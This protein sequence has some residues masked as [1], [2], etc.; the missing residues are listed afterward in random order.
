MGVAICR[1][2][3]EDETDVDGATC[4]ICDE[5]L[6]VRSDVRYEVKIE[7][8]A[9]YDPMEI[10]DEDLNQDHAAKIKELIQKM[11][12]LSADEAQNQVYRKFAFDLCPACQR[13]Y[14]K[15]PL[16]KADGKRRKVDVDPVVRRWLLMRARETYIV[17]SEI[18]GRVRAAEPPDPR[19]A[20]LAL[21]GELMAGGLLQAG[22]P[23]A[24]EGTFDPWP[25]NSG[26]MLTRLEADWDEIGEVVWFKNT[27]AGNAEA[28]RLGSHE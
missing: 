22:V 2:R 5:P 18:A 10:T 11:E 6:L 26:R 3:G 19:R 14:I 23:G 4:D 21:L 7:V 15:D 28:D 24:E 8:K 1:A 27:D 20:T 25:M 12:G 13:S 9:A 16:I 17:L